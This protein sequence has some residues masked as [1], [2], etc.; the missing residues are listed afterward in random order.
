MAVDGDTLV[1]GSGNWQASDETGSAHVFTYSEITDTWSWQADLTASD[2]A[3]NDVFG[4]S[5]IVAGDTIVVGAP[6][7]DHSGLVNAGAAYVFTRSGETWNEKK[8]MATDAEAGDCFGTFVAI[9]DDTIMVSAQWDNEDAGSVYVFTRSGNDWVEQQKITAS[10][11]GAGDWFG[12]S[13]VLSGDTAIIS[14]IHNDSCGYQDAGAVYIFAR[15]DGIWSEQ[16]KITAGDA[17]DGDELGWGIPA[18]GDIVLMGAA[19]DDHSGLEDAGS[20][21]VYRLIPAPE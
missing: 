21:Y 8:L 18:F 5:V 15:S 16:R 12:D 4:Q 17:D 14:A 3:P 2:G 11:G 13:T 19:M 7:A 10:D 1:V 9:S 20:V 6:L